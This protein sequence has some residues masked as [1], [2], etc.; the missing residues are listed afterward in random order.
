MSA[1]AT[2]VPL[3][4]VPEPMTT[5]L[6]NRAADELDAT[7]E[8]KEPPLT[9]SQYIREAWHVIEPGTPY[10]HGWHIDALAEHLE[11]L[12]RGEIRNLLITMPPRHMKSICVAVMW[13]T[14]VWT[15]C[16]EKRFLFA[17]YAQ[18]LSTRDSVKCRRIIESPWYRR[19][20]GHM[21]TLTSDMNLKMRFENSRMGYRLAT[22]VGGSNTGEG[23][24]FLACLP[25]GA[26]V[27]TPRGDQ[28]IGA[29]VETRADNY[30]LGPSG[31]NRIESYQRNP[32]KPIIEFVLS[33]GCTLN[34]TEDHPV[35]T[36]ERGYIPAKVVSLSYGKF[37]LRSLHRQFSAPPS[38]CGQGKVD[39]LFSSMLWGET[40]RPRQSDVEGRRG[41][42][43]LHA[44]QRAICMQAQ[45]I[46]QAKV[47]FIC[48]WGSRE[49]RAQAAQLSGMSEFFYPEE[50]QSEKLFE[51]LRGQ[52][53][54]DTCT[55]RKE[56]EVSYWRMVSKIFA[57][58][59]AEI[60]RCHQ[61]ER[62]ESV[63]H[64]LDATWPVT[65]PSYR[66]DSVHP[67]L[68]KFSD[69]LH[70]MSSQDPHEDR[71]QPIIDEAV[72]IT[73]IR[74]LP[75]PAY[76]YNLSV[77]PDHA[78]YADNILVHNCDDAH[79]I[80]EVSSKIKR[81]AVIDWWDQVMSTRGNDPKTV[82]KVVVAQRCHHQDLPGHILSRGGWDH[83][84]LP[85]EYEGAST[86]TSIGWVDPRK[87][88]GDLL[89]A[90][91]F[92]PVEIAQLKK[93]LGSYAA[94]GQLQ[95]RPSPLEGG[96]VKRHW[97]QWYQAAPECEEYI[98]S[99]DCAFKDT[100]TSSYVVG[101][102]WGRKD[103]DFYL[104]DQVRDHLDFTSTLRAIRSLS[105]KWPQAI[106]KYIEDKAN[107]TAIINTLCHEIVGII[108]VNP[109][110]SKQARFASVTPV[111]ES[112]NVYL[113]QG[114]PWSDDVVEEAAAFPDGPFDDI[115]DSTSQALN[116]LTHTGSVGITV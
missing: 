76:V 113:K 64:M 108:P 8:V 62:R 58:V 91:R 9:L 68:D 20:W 31:W 115:C 74:C 3:L 65:G 47:L 99:W 36:E 23:G 18:G 89:W 45:R 32:G 96:M 53:S 38:P 102:V 72:G 77:T 55:W 88:D 49:T 80:K 105:Q 50:V 70:L 25:W 87:D 104:L 1:S 33:N 111:I 83:L 28:C 48:L 5:T 114:A 116:E 61:S 52:D 75:S 30:V 41:D 90:G 44:L 59:Y 94:A 79:N 26:T 85:A 60:A 78:F 66:R 22:S 97:W 93:D 54:S 12:T 92:G 95:Q 14:W 2:L 84:N 82:G 42:V 63:R 35:W 69:A 67:C 98:Q 57:W 56:W 73:A 103:A 19:R 101:Q 24:D 109:T 46:A 71:H 16:P 27:M 15:T 106:A 112:G 86:P 34:A 29:V 39:S 10:V 13:P 37:H 110:D 4:S 100:K 11:A 6:W 7:V 81:T 107:G 21:A 40:A 51:A 43:G 17:S